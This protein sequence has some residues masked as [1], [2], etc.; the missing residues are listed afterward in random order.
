MSH[1]RAALFLGIA[2]GACRTPPVE[3]TSVGNPGETRMSMA[4]GTGL[5]ID[6]A[7]VT[8]VRTRWTDCAG[9]V[10]TLEEEQQV[11][12]LDSQVLQTPPGSWC[13]LEVVTRGATTVAATSDAGFGAA[14]SLELGTLGLGTSA[15]FFIDGDVLALELGTPGWLDAAA[16]GADTADVVVNAG[17]AAHAGLVAA[18][19]TGAGLYPDDGDGQ[20]SEGERGD[21]PVADGATTTDDDDD[22]DDDD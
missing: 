15:P 16:L 13:G 11:D 3:G 21:G 14:I 1:R 2:L 9:V 22:D 18:A 10:T 8:V 12:L 20:V 7:E 6:A 17:S 19:S 4:K 5:T